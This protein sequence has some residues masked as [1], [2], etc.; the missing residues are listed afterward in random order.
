LLHNVQ[1][2]PTPALEA[3]LNGFDPTPGGGG[4]A[5]P[6][7]AQAGHVAEVVGAVVTTAAT[8]AAAH[9][10][11]QPA[12]DPSAAR[13][14]PTCGKAPGKGKFCIECGAFVGATAAAAPAPVETA[15]TGTL[16]HHAA[17][18]PA[19]GE[20][21]PPPFPTFANAGQPVAQAEPLRKASL[22]ES[23]QQIADQSY[24]GSPYQQPGQEPQGVIQGAKRQAVTSFNLD[25]SRLGYTPA[26]GGKPG[27]GGN[28]E[29]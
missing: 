10:M 26:N 22:F 5:M 2:K 6:S 28:V 29:F 3:P 21:A 24:G 27:K 18:A 8:A 11:A 14:C 7:F 16:V 20:P 1:R 9:A 13:A 19:P 23:P 25:P 17:P 12:V 15:V 4:H